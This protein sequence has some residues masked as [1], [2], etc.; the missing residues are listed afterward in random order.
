M[1]IGSLF[2]QKETPKDDKPAEAKEYQCIMCKRH[3]S[4]VSGTE[5]YCCND[6][7]CQEQVDDYLDNR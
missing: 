6:P 2:G 7:W 3:G 5:I 4:K 1:R